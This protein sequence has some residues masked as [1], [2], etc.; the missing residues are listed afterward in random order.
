MLTGQVKNLETLGPNDFRRISPRFQGENFRKNL[1]LVARVEKMAAEKGCTPAQLALAWVLQQGN[2]L[3]P[4]P[5][6]KRRTYLD[7]NLA[8][9]D[10]SFTPAELRRIDEIAPRGVA[11][12]TRYP[13][14][15]M[16]R[17]GV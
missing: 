12:G 10:I 15:H 6:T 3:V 13:A 14:E 9:L 17:V 7:Q 8:A 1:E 11:A 4:I 5:G 16:S 2:D